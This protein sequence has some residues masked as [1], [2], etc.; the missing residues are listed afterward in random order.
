MSK[1]PPSITKRRRVLRFWEFICYCA[2]VGVAILPSPDVDSWTLPM[3]LIKV[4]L[5]LA[6]IVLLGVIHSRKHL[7]KL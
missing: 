2:F 4:V 6:L 5:V 1:N 3:I 7:L